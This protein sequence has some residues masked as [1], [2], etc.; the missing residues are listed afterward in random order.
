VA[1]LCSLV[2]VQKVGG[3][4]CVVLLLIVITPIIQDNHVP[5]IFVCLIATSSW[6]YA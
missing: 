5:V 3:F 2:A 6:M 1:H 4:L